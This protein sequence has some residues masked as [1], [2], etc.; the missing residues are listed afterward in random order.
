MKKIQ[1]FLLLFINF[2]FKHVNE[3]GT[4]R[5]IEYLSIKKFNKLFLPPKF[6]FAPQ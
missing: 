3:V 1:N 4:Q 6:P 2:L 5:L